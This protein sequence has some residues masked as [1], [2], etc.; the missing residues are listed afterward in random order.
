MTKQLSI[1]L[2]ILLC[3]AASAQQAIQ[4]TLFLKNGDIV[5]GKLVNL[6]PNR[7]VKI[8]TD[9]GQ[10]LIPIAD[11]GD[12]GV[13]TLKLNVSKR[14]IREY[15]ANNAYAENAPVPEPLPEPTESTVPI[16]KKQ[17]FIIQAGIGDFYKPDVDLSDNLAIG[18]YKLNVTYDFFFYH[19]IAVG[20]STGIKSI[21]NETLVP[22]MIDLRYF[23]PGKKSLSSFA[24]DAGYSYMFQTQYL[25]PSIDASYTFG[26]K[27]FK[28]FY[29][30]IGADINIQFSPTNTYSQYESYG[31]NLGV[32][33]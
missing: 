21:L 8:D 20:A 7:T 19:S 29:L 18:S 4:D 24:L 12:A 3:T 30:T 6:G 16:E 2:L 14:Q 27:V 33:F 23:N 28:S 26:Y 11:I 25:A 22:L 13:H 10:L 17:L 32:I 15:L 1:L 31:I 9:R 5:C